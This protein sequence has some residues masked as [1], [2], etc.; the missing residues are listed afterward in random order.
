MTTPSARPSLYKHLIG[1][2]GER[3]SVLPLTKATLVHLSHI[4][5]DIVLRNDLPAFL[6][7][8]F[9]ESSHWRSET[10]R[11][12]ELAGRLRQVTIFA[13]QPL[14]D[15]SVAN[16][17]Q[18]TLDDDDPFRQEWFLAVL[19]AEFSAVLCGLDNLEPA[20]NES[21]R[22]FDTIWSFEPEV[23][24]IA[25]D[26]VEQQLAHYYPQRSEAL[27]AVRN[28]FPLRQPDPKLLIEFTTELILFEEK[29]N[30]I[31]FEQS[32]ILRQSETLQMLAVRSAPILMVAFDRQSTITY[33]DWDS[34]PRV[35]HISPPVV[36]DGMDALAKELE[37]LDAMLEKI[38]AG[39]TAFSRHRWQDSIEIEL[40]GGPVFHNNEVV[41][42]VLVLVDVTDVR[43]AEQVQREY[44]KLQSALEQERA[45]SL[46]KDRIM[47]IISHE[48]RTPLATMLNAS[49]LLID[50]R[51]RLSE[52]EFN[53]GLYGIQRQILRL[54]EMVQDVSMVIRQSTDGM[55]LQATPVDLK[56]MIDSEVENLRAVY[57]VNQP[58][59]NDCRLPSGQNVLLDV[60]VFRRIV[61]NLL[62]NAAKY[63]GPNSEITVV[64]D[65]LDGTLV[66]SVS[67]KGIGIPEADRAMIFEPF[68][69]G[70]N[71][72]TIGGLGLG[73]AIVRDGAQLH[74]G[75]V[76]VTS[77]EGNGTTFTVIV[78]LQLVPPKDSRVD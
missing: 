20:I 76:E 11:Y 2:M 18:I 77:E 41:G 7:T 22:R 44:D 29:L 45:V 43:R 60:R 52:D 15:D 31:I 30:S 37:G 59:I 47:R 16:V 49:Q 48:F 12:R 32:R 6:F 14:P 74:G 8:G 73:L 23:V 9:Q 46:L 5:E 33:Y 10:E 24:N 25:L 64:S 36:G 42:G 75:T 58:I 34:V 17:L 27:R 19:S 68:Q 35:R 57:N 21:L 26:V 61:H 78:P 70:D 72:G 1:K 66:L 71:V 69:R 63:S 3:V 38:F 39:E 56:D 28:E 13:G 67:D 65:A 62:S 51:D 55:S 53:D 54:S 50:F 4:L 40:H